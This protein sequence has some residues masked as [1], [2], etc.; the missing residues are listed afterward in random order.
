MVFGP[1]NGTRL[2]TFCLVATIDTCSK[3]TIEKK[4]C[5]ADE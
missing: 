4:T 3:G 5:E 2:A 1:G